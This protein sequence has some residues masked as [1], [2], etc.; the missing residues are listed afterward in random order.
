MPE[1]K[2]NSKLIETDFLKSHNPTTFFVPVH[3]STL[4]FSCICSVLSH[5]SIYSRHP[6]VYTLL[7]VY[8]STCL[9]GFA[10]LYSLFTSWLHLINTFF[11]L[12]FIYEFS[13]WPYLA[14]L[15]GLRGLRSVLTF[16]YDF[17]CICNLFRHIC[18][19]F[20][21]KEN[22]AEKTG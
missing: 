19:P 1:Q 7:H 3:R 12:F 5:T 16:N 14:G 9:W 10:Y 20:S 2:V 11:I 21:K 18:S 6:F 22:I 13:F 8:M 4:S 17:S 15:G